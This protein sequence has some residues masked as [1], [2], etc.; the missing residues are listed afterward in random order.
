[1]ESIEAY[2]DYLLDTEGWLPTIPGLSDPLM[3][4]Y[5]INWELMRVWGVDTDQL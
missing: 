5:A 4:W 3:K 1:M 2:G